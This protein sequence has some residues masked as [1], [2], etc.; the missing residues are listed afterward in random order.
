MEFQ[1][2]LE[3]IIEIV[4]EP[5]LEQFIDTVSARNLKTMF[6]LLYIV[7]G[8]NGRS[9]YRRFLQVPEQSLGI[10][11]KSRRQEKYWLREVTVDIC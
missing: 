11:G 4:Y 3:Q 8:L 2:L 6:A 10:N 5:G 1:T 9:F 7:K